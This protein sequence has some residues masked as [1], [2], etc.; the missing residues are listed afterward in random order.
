[1]PKGG[2]GDLRM[3]KIVI[4][5]RKKTYPARH[6]SGEHVAIK[7]LRIELGAVNSYA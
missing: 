5:I 6:G 3:S 2:G 4:D 7:N 1:M